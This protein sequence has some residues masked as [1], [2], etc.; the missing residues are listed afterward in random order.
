MSRRFH[1]SG[2][3]SSLDF[4]NTGAQ[5]FEL[6]DAPEALSAWIAAV[7]LGEAPSA[8]SESDLEDVRDLRDRLRAALLGGDTRRVAQ[9]VGDWLEPAVVRICVDPETLS[10]RHL[11][12][13][14]TA[15]CALVPVALDALDLVRSHSD[16]V[17]ECAS[18]D[19]PALFLDLS[20]NRSRRWCSMDVCGARAKARVYYRRHRGG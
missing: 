18:D 14:R 15:R 7:G 9:L 13:E 4:C 12:A 16:R 19:C 6:L 3:R 2:E 8:I 1:V 17:R 11:P 10:P 5:S 20:R